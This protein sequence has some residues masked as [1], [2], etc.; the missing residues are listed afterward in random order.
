MHLALLCGREGLGDRDP[1]DDVDPEPDRAEE[2]GDQHQDAGHDDVDVVIV[3]ILMLVALICGTL[4]FW[5]YV[6][7]W[8]AVP[9]AI[10]PAQKCE[11]HGLPVTAE[12]MAKF[13][14][15][16]NY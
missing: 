13:A 9:E 10:T 14:R 15:T 3:R 4:G 2:D 7:C 8:I 1:A 11:M 12:N 5:I 6:I 16:Q